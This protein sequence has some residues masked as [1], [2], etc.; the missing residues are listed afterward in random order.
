VFLIIAGMEACR[1][2]ELHDQPQDTPKLTKISGMTPCNESLWYYRIA[3]KENKMKSML[4]RMIFVAT[5]LSRA[6]PKKRSRSGLR[7]RIPENQKIRAPN[8][9]LSRR[10][11]HHVRRTTQS[12]DSPFI[13]ISGT[14]ALS[15]TLRKLLN[16]I[17]FPMQNGMDLKGSEQDIE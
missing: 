14:T 1:N 4:W 13:P 9:I 5:R 17:L 10:S 16:R 15:F 11:L 6:V 3:R 7:S 2:H 12:H 8:P